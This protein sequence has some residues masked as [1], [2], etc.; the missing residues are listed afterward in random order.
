R[1][2]RMREPQMRQLL[3]NARHPARNIDQN[4]ADLRAQVAANEKGRE[5]LMAMVRHFGLEAVQAYMRHV[6]DNAEESVRR[7]I[8]RLHD[9][10]HTVTLDNGAQIRVAVRV[11]RARRSATLDFTGT[12]EQRPDN[13]NAPRAV[14]AAAVLYVFR[15]LLDDD[16]PMNAG[17]LKPLSIV[18][19]EGSMLSPRHPAA[20][21]AGNEIRRASCTDTASR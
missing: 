1:D 5:E 13:F 20:V 18:V 9:G 10:S 17:G 4:I 19:P 3:S 2:G 14:T 11:D 21:V 6:Q 7:A 15:T 8:G 16:I 12:S